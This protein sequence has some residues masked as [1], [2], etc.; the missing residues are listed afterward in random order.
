[1][2]TGLVRALLGSTMGLQPVPYSQLNSQLS[3][4][5]S[6]LPTLLPVKGRSSRGRP[7]AQRPH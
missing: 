7:L 1:M 6:K 3:P 5:Q 4:A 2:T